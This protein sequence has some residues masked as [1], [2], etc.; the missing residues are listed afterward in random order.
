MKNGTKHYLKCSATLETD[1][2]PSKNNLKLKSVYEKN[3]QLI[4]ATY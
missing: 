3:I 2:I 4:Y 1:D